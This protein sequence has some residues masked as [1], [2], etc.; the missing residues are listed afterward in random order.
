MHP[1]SCVAASGG[2]ASGVVRGDL[3]TDQ[4]GVDRLCAGH[5]HRQGP[6]TGHGQGQEQ[7]LVRL[8]L[9]L[10]SVTCDGFCL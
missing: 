1:C 2:S 7:A 4:R 5:V 6:R 9:I 3:P 8:P 10:S